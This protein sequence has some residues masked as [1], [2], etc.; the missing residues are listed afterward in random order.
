[1]PSQ[2]LVLTSTADRWNGTICGREVDTPELGARESLCQ[3]KAKHV[4]MGVWEMER[5]GGKV[6]GGSQ[7]TPAKESSESHSKTLLRCVVQILRF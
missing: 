5:R 2:V 6:R 3:R 7:V 4:L 1:M